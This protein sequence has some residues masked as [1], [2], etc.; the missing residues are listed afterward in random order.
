V[1]EGDALVEQETKTSAAV[2]K[3]TRVVTSSATSLAWIGVLGLIGAATSLLFKIFENP[4]QAKQ[5]LP[6]IAAIGSGIAG[7][8]VAYIFWRFIVGLQQESR[9][10]AHNI[11]RR[12]ILASV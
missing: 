2:R 11:S 12:D 9:T 1:D 7:V 8:F 10:Y 3:W 6:V 5:A 4:E